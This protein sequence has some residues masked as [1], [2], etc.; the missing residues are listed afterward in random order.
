MG[1]LTKA[2]EKRSQLTNPEQWLLSALGYRPSLSGVNV[3]ENR[4]INSSVVWRAVTLLG[5]TIGSLPLVVYKRK[6]P[7]G[8]EK[9]PSH[10]LYH[11]LHDRPNPEMSSLTWRTMGIAHQLVWGNWYNEIE[12]DKD[13]YPIAFWPL[14]PWLTKPVRTKKRALF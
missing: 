13:G 4:S 8:K 3:S 1:I 9:D 5:G 14:A 2:F 7:R 12:F 10:N 11:A 6:Q